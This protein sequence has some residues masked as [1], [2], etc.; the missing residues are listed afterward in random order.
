MKA[1]NS[2]I[3]RRQTL[4][5]LQ[6]HRQLSLILIQLNPSIWNRQNSFSINMML[7]RKVNATKKRKVSS[8]DSRSERQS[9]MHYSR[10]IS[11]LLMQ[12]CQFDSV[13]KASSASVTIDGRQWG[14]TYPWASELGGW[15]FCVLLR[16]VSMRLA[17]LNIVCLY[18]IVVYMKTRN[19]LVI[20][21]RLIPGLA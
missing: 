17:G 21:S 6:R 1:E 14:L 9:K 15:F 8:I 12:S 11:S 19:S 7:S 4:R 5:T 18:L 16:H 10:A 13:S 3:T 20:V 2:L